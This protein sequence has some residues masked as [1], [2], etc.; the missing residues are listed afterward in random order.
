MGYNRF[1]IG[2]VF[3]EFDL[4]KPTTFIQNYLYELS[5][6]F[7]TVLYQFL[8]TG[9][10]DRSL[11]GIAQRLRF[12]GFCLYPFHFSFTVPLT[13]ILTYIYGSIF[14]FLCFMVILAEIYISI[15][16]SVYLSLIH[17]CNLKQVNFTTT[18]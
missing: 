4:F 11:I 14:I 16:L 13:S 3:V 1:Q 18:S 9:T 5:Y 15:Y 17:F 2:F 12:S 7:D 8:E 6:N 10:L